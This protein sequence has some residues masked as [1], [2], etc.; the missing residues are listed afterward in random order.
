MDANEIKV[1]MAATY[2]I[3]SDFYPYTVVAVER[4]GK[5]VTLQEDKTHR[6]GLFTPDANGRKVVVSLRKGGVYVRV[7]EKR[8]GIYTMG[9]R[10]HDLD[11][12]F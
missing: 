2:Q 10:R 11:P 1:G 7:G 5:R 9:K 4:D 6:G 8:C 3:G 12:C